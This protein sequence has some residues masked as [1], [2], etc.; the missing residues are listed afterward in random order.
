M[1]GKKVKALKPTGLKLVDQIE[2]NKAAKTVKKTGSM[3]PS[4]QQGKLIL[5]HLVENVIGQVRLVEAVV[6]TQMFFSLSV[7][8]TDGRNLTFVIQPGETKVEIPSEEQLTE[9]V[10]AAAQAT[11]HGQEGV[12]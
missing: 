11:E 3:A 2:R 10:A 5:G 6:G 12:E 9:K 1:T 8:M 7:P 4:E